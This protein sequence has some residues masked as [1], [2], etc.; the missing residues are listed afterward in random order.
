MTIDSRRIAT[1]LETNMNR[2]FFEL[3]NNQSNILSS[4]E[5]NIHG[6]LKT[7]QTTDNMKYSSMVDDIKR[8]GNESFHLLQQQI[9]ENAE[10]VALLAFNQQPLVTGII[11][12]N[13]V[14]YS[15]GFNNLA[16]FTNTGKIVCEKSGLYMIT[17]SIISSTTASQFNIVLNS[18]MITGNRFVDGVQW[19]TGTSGMVLQLHTGDNIWVET[20]KVLSVSGRSYNSFSIIKI[21]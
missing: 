11:K 17:V 12:F 10:Q 4:F 3:V 9:E 19:H 14:K 13:D 1:D 5:S 7:I 6:Q 21:K 15:V 2:Q 8:Q 16:T 18:K 20:D